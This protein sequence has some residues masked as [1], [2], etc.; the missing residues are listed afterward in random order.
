MMLVAQL[1]Q[2]K[3]DT[4]YQL[5]YHS[6][7]LGVLLLDQRHVIPLPLPLNKITNKIQ[8]TRNL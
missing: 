4:V 5:T 7:Q 8:R 3:V 6:L 2:L 1:Q